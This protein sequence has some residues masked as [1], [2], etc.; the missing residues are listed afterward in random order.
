MKKHITLLFVA[1]AVLIHSCA[2]LQQTPD[3]RPNFL[4]IIS[5]D[6]RYDTMEFMPITQKLIFDQG[7]TFSNGYV[8][9]PLCCPSRASILTG[10]YAHNNNVRQN[11]DKLT[12]RTI[13][14]DMHDAGYF[15]GLVGKYLN[16][17]SDNPRPE[18]DYWVSFWGGTPKRYYE[19]RLNINGTRGKIPGYITYLLKD[20]VI[21][22]LDLAAQKENPFFL[23]FTPNAPHEPYTPANEDLGLY[24]GLPLYRP[25]SFNEA[26]I[27]DK[28]YWFE[29]KALRTPEEI[30][31]IDQVRLAE[32]Q[33]LASLDR[34]I[35]EIIKKLEEIG[36]LD[37]TVIIYMSDN[38]KAWFEHRLDSKN[39]VYEESIKVPYALRYPTLVPEPYIEK[40]LVSNIDIAPTVYELS[41]LTIPDSV[42]GLSMT[43]LFSTDA[44]WRETL[45][46]ESWPDPRPWV[47][48][49]TEYQIYVETENDKSEYY[50]LSVDPYQLNNAID[51][52]KYKNVIGYLKKI[53]DKD[54]IPK[55]LP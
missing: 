37:N 55:I 23:L 9:T 40:R 35:G 19:P 47:A 18:F 14:E 45:I 4:V 11:E 51:D 26:D 5:D 46:I 25:P 54:K 32:I 21:E 3:E 41:G 8:T 12:V 39:N 43:R 28:P 49:H 1:S 31:S 42:D 15:T 6:Q 48:I 24:T 53:M 33:T 30:A 27:S 16:S 20:H 10:M 36:E 13:A 34:S 7:V 38:G 17:W 22:F 44:D 2:F 29:I 50:D 52:P